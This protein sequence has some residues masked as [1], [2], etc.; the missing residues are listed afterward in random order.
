MVKYAEKL[1]ILQGNSNI[2]KTT[3]LLAVIHQMKQKGFS[4][5]E[6]QPRKRDQRVLLKDAN[7][8]AVVICTGGD[9]LDII[10]QNYRF[11]LEHDCDVM[12][13]ACSINVATHVHGTRTNLMKTGLIGF[14]SGYWK[15]REVHFNE[16]SDH[17]K[18]F[19][20]TSMK[21]GRDMAIAIIE[22]ILKVN[23][24]ETSE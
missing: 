14:A 10:E 17:V 15:S 5:D 4:T 16:N 24:H 22:E 21:D 6:E 3:T 2:G 9:S 13:S 23:K 19:T 11:F 7:G 12:V 1:I 20:L 18:I 8:F